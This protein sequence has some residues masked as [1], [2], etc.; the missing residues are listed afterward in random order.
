MRVS[1]RARP[2]REINCGRTHFAQAARKRPPK[3]MTSRRH[4]MHGAVI[5]QELGHGVE[6]FG[7][8]RRLDC[9]VTR[10]CAAVDCDRF[11]GMIQGNRM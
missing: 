8:D 2:A 7:D 5:N 9:R 10:R 11:N 3:S 6:L 1:V 4:S